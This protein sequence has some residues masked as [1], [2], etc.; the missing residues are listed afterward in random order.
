MFTKSTVK[1]NSS[2]INCHAWLSYP[3]NYN[4][5]KIPIVIMAHGFGGT[6][7]LLLHN[8]AEQ[9]NKNGYATL[10]FDYRYWGESEGTPRNLH[11]FKKQIEDWHAAI[12]YA[13]TIPNVDDKKVILWGTSFA[14]GLVLMAAAED[15]TIAATI[16]QCPMLDGR[17]TAIEFI[18]YSGIINAIKSGIHGFVDILSSLFG[19]THYVKIWGKPN[20]IA[21]MATQDAYDFLI[22]VDKIYPERLNQPYYNKITARS[23]LSVGNC[24]PITKVKNVKCPALLLICENDSVAPV[25]S[26]KDAIKIMPNPVAVSYPIGHFD[27]YFDKDFDK[28]MEDQIKFLKKYI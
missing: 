24:R 11:D 22:K 14:G 9:F 2:G 20:E 17:L 13:K 26:V 16:S 28:S 19:K 10:V 25:K 7:A 8:Y 21:A 12:A 1:F 3:E 6:K 5:E 18:K 23:L 27:P 15:N 4:N